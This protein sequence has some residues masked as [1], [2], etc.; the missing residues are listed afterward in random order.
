MCL[1]IKL[2]VFL[3]DVYN[4]P[5]CDIFFLVLRRGESGCSLLLP[6]STHVRLL[7]PAVPT[8]ISGISQS[9][10]MGAGDFPM[11]MEDG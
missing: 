3:D 6:P 4:A 8:E 9:G 2:E 10:I 11:D 7:L 5:S 1:S